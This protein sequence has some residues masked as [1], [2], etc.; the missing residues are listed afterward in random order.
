LKSLDSR[1]KDNAVIAV[2]VIAAIAVSGAGL[3]LSV[4]KSASAGNQPQG[5]VVN[6]DVIPDYGGAGYDAFVL[7]ANAENGVVPTPAT[8][9]TAPS[10]IDNNVTVAAGTTVKFVLTTI[11]TAVLQNFS[12]QVS[13]PFTVYNDTASGV[14]ASHYGQ[15]Q[16]ISNMPIG[17]TFTITQLGVNIPIPPTT[18]VTFSLTFSKSG[19]YMFMCDTPCGPGMGLVGYMEGYVIV[20]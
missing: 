18:V 11:D 15:G 1:T 10:I 19:V 8:N 3:Y 6:M 5:N 12:S 20:T 13:I 14:V 9:T 17:H 4:I 2:L 7:S 16:S